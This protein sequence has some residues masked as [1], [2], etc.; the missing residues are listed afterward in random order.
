MTQ[1]TTNADNAT[2]VSSAGVRQLARRSSAS[3]FGSAVTAV[4]QLGLSVA[5]ARGLTREDAGLF[6]SATSLFLIISTVVKL[7]TPTGL[8][9]ALSGQR[10]RG[11][12]SRINPTLRIALLPVLIAGVVA[13][14]AMLL[15]A[16]NLATWLLDSTASPL[17]H[18]RLETSLRIMAVF[19]PVAAMYDAV[20]AASRGAGVMRPTIVIERLA[21]PI[22]QCLLVVAAAL[23]GSLVGAS[24]GWVLPY[25]V[26]LVL[27]IRM[28]RRI[29][30]KVTAGQGALV[31][32]AEIE[33][34]GR[35]PG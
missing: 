35:R 30:T 20:T 15:L 26:A 14:L 33:A 1:D 32:P 8:V 23:A 18:Q 3:L 7:G 31:A 25:A 28:T 12:L 16:G 10:A 17:T 9:W 13:G 27:M 4:A 29:V 22:L 11:E 19:V 24:L 6:F 21:R 5:V 34:R 2:G